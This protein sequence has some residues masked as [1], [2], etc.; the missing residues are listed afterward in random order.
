MTRTLLACGLVLVLCRPALADA[1]V[2]TAANLAFHNSFWSNLHHTLFGA[3]WAARADTGGRRLIPALPDP[4]MAPLS[5]AERVGWEAAVAYYAAELADRDL[6]TGR[7]MT[8]IKLALADERLD[9]EAISPEHKAMLERAA[10]IYRRHFWAAHERSNR[11]WIDDVVTR[12]QTLQ[13]EMIARLERLYQRSWFT[14]PIRVDVVWV[15]RAYTTLHPTHAVV[16]PAEP[17]MTGWTALEI[18]VHEASHELILPTETAIAAALG[19]RRAAHGDLWHVVQFFVSGTAIQQ[20][21]RERGIDYTPYLYATGLFDR[22]WKRYRPAIE[23]HWTP[24]VRGE[25]TREQAIART[26]AEL[27]R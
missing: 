14:A 10:P 12:L 11:A 27:T 4:L 1:P 9:A 24:Y 17:D 13:P 16:S 26:I 6:R 15:G 18:V 22:A 5:D 19:D 20:L 8:A 2:T 21:L 3:A 23:A 25:I 7:G